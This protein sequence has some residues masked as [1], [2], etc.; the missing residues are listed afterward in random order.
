MPET[1]RRPLRKF[2][3]KPRPFLE[4]FESFL[5]SILDD[6]SCWEW[7]GGKGPNGYGAIAAPPSPGIKQ[8]RKI[9]AHRAAWEIYHAQPVPIGLNVCHRCDN[10]RCVNPL[11]LF[12]G[13]QKENLRDMMIKNRHPSKRLSS[14]QALSI[15]RDPRP[16]RIVARDFGIS[17]RQVL[18]IRR[19]LQWKH[20]SSQSHD[21]SC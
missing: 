3:P 15:L 12:L 7:Q 5:P 11:H 16:S 20:L 9:L 2:G 1:R 4:R 6:R 18:N 14:E 10:R 13:T 19:G 8:P 21:S 17:H